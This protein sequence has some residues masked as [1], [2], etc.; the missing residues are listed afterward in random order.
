MEAAE[1]TEIRQLA[2]D[3]LYEEAVVR[4]TFA[5]ENTPQPDRELFYL[6]GYARHYLSR[7]EKSIEGRERFG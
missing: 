2:A 1:L 6:R 7:Y 3:A 5:I 4:A